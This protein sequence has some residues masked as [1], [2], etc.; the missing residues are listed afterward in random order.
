MNAVQDFCCSIFCN[1]LLESKHIH[2]QV[3]GIIINTRVK[4]R[5]KGA[6]GRCE[7]YVCCRGGLEAMSRGGQLSNFF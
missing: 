5:Q 1:I 7:A 2:V 4:I 6:R 3:H